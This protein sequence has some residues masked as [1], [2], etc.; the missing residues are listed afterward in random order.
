MNFM[1][2]IIVSMLFLA[3][4]LT[5]Y[6]EYMKYGLQYE[7]ITIINGVEII[8]VR[9]TLFNSIFVLLFSLLVLVSIM[10]CQVYHTIKKYLGA[11][12]SEQ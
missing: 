9:S 5:T 12:E 7:V 4:V 11:E 10:N 8:S 6:T 1:M 3:G 2:L